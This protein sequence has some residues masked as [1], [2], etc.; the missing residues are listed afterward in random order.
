MKEAS[1]AKVSP[2]SATPKGGV[3]ALTGA[4]ANLPPADEG[5]DSDVSEE[6][7]D[8]DG[9][10]AQVSEDGEDSEEVG[11]LDFQDR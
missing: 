4:L 7:T 5:W 9:E 2:V 11:G 6:E 3:D 10:E 1:K 8:T